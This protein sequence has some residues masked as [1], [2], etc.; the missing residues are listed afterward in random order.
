MQSIFVI[1]RNPENYKD[2][3]SIYDNPLASIHFRVPLVMV[4]LN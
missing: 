1:T 2:K 3:K 4:E